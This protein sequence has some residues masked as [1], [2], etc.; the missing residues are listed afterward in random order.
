MCT[1]AFHPTEMAACVAPAGR[2]GVLE[3]SFT[4]GVTDICCLYCPACSLLRPS[5]VSSPCLAF[6]SAPNGQQCSKDRETTTTMNRSWFRLPFGGGNTSQQQ[7]QEEDEV[8]LSH[9]SG[10]LL[11]ALSSS[12]QQRHNQRRARTSNSSGGRRDGFK[13]SIS[14][15]CQC[16]LSSSLMV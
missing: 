8:E 11:P 1:P 15:P 4:D 2:L 5:H 3:S 10:E 9:D 14:G 16:C 13:Q 6:S 7:Q 12:R